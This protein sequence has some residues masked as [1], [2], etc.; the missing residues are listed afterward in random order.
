MAV[1]IPVGKSNFAIIDDKDLEMVSSYRWAL[2]SKRYAAA[3]HNSKTILM[4]RLILNPPI[5]LFVD[6][7][8][9]D[10]LDNRRSNLRHCD[11]RQN[12]ANRKPKGRF[13]GVQMR[14][15]RFRAYIKKTYL[16]VFNSERDAAIAYDTAARVEHGEFA[17]L[18]FPSVVRSFE[19]V[20]QSRVRRARS[21]NS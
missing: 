15:G 13:L 1:E 19:E 10:G 3:W 17:N 18:N 4:H 16:G 11:Y 2:C 21:V 6:H 8:N 9:G 5:G 20:Q 14:D 7:V 12:G